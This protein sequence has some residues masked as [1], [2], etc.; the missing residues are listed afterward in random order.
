MNNGLDLWPD[1]IIVGAMKCATSTLHDQLNMQSSFFMADPKEPYF[2]SDDGVYYAKGFSWYHSLFAGAESSQL[3]G[4][5]STHYTKLP[6]YPATVQ[7]IVSSCPHVKCIYIMRHPVDRLVSHYIHEWTQGIISCTIDEAVVT[8]PEL[9]AYSRYNMQLEPYLDT[10][11]DT[12]I[13]PMFSERFRL[14]PQSELQAVFDFLGVEEQPVWHSNI[15]SNVSADR[16][17]NC[18]WRDAIVNNVALRFLRRKFVPKKFRTII[19]NYWTMRERPE[20]S[21]ES[22]KYVKG[23]FDHDLRALGGKLG[24]DLNCDSYREQVLSLEKIKWVL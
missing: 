7:R 8:H 5:S 20:L 19:K 15:K 22:L 10:F 17:R 12:A 16:L 4:E 18:A 1:F 11:G 2:F 21:S 6:T 23:F 24:L 13:L 14:N 3:K 9:I